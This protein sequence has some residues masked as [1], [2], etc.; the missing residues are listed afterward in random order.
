MG[1]L[2]KEDRRRWRN[3]LGGFGVEFRDRRPDRGEEQ[4]YD[5]HTRATIVDLLARSLA[6]GL[7]RRRRGRGRKKSALS[8]SI[9]DGR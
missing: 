5:T 4:V 6:A 3:R 8:M 7:A 2:V 9:R 1:K